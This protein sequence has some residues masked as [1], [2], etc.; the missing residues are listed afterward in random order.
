MGQQQ[1]FLVV[2]VT[3]IV[4]LATI[5]AI[6][7]FQEAHNN[8]AY[9]AIQQDILQA[10]SQ[11]IAYIK[12]SKTMGGGGGSYLGMSHADILLPLENENA[13][14]SLDEITDDSF[15]IIAESGYDFTVTATISGEQIQW[16]T[17]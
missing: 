15:M 10:H 3:L 5:V 11:S 2:L 16:L 1:M 17:E 7:N 12:R 14:Y 13:T 4:G 8:S 9:E 6:F